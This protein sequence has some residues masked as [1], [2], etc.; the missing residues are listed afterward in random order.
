MLS[1]V[2]LYAT[3]DLISSGFQLSLIFLGILYVHILPSVLHH[4]SPL[5][6]TRELTLL[7]SFIWCATNITLS[8]LVLNVRRS[9]SERRPPEHDTV[10]AGYDHDSEVLVTPEDPNIIPYDFNVGCEEYHELH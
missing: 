6:L 2:V 3:Q 9:A 10:T 5:G 1:S 4:S 8:H 7:C